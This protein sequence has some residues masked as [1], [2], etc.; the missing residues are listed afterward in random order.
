MPAKTLLRGTWVVPMSGRPIRDGGVLFAGDQILEVGP[1]KAIATAHP[2]IRTLDRPGFTVMP[3]LVNPHTHLE[4]SEFHCGARPASFV[5]WIMRLVPRGQT[6]TE[7]V[8]ASVARSIPL[9]VAQCLRFGVTCVGDISRHCAVSRPRLRTG[10]LRVVSYGEVQAMAQRRALLEERIATA[11]DE[12][13]ASDSLRIGLSPHAP[14]SVELQGYRRCLAVARE[15][16][17]PLATHLAETPDEATFLEKH[18][19]PFRDLWGHIGAWDDQVPRFSGGPIRMAHEVGLLDYPTLLAHV[20]YCDDDEM[21][22]LSHGKASVVYCPR[23]HA[24]FDHPPHRWRAMLDVGINVAIGTDSCAS[25]PDLNLLEELRVLRRI[26]PNFPAARLWE[27]ATIRAARAIQMDRQVGTLEEGKRADMVLF[28][29]QASDPQTHI[30][31]EN[32]VPA[33]TW[34]GGR[35]CSPG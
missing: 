3:G 24:F 26:A 21:A 29:T 7:S 11:I 25:S 4:L 6:T 20:N 18:A 8:R 30:L 19:G 13:F 9:G 35:P 31:D 34:I 16:G 28:A 12:T 14:F 10:A 33:E 23:T 17:L 2:D 32:L 27:M 15:K 5:D 1:G 22:L